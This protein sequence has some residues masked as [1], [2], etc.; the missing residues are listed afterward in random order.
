M[1]VLSIIYNLSFRGSEFEYLSLFL[2]SKK[3]LNNKP[4]ENNAAVPIEKIWLLRN[5]KLCVCCPSTSHLRYRHPE[6]HHVLTE[7]NL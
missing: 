3:P 5:H 4:S 2:V 6:P 1:E 7:F